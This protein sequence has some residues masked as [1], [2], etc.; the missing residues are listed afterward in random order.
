MIDVKNVL[1]NELSEI[2]DNDV[3]LLLSG[4]VDSCSLLFAL[5]ELNKNVHAYSFTLDDRE[6]SDFKNAKEVCKIFNI[7]FSPIY[8]PTDL[9]ILQKDLLYLI[10]EFN[11]KKKTEIECS[12]AMMYAIKAIKEKTIVAGL[13]ADGHFCISKKGMIHYRHTV[14][15]M[16]EFRNGLFTNPNYSQKQIV[17][18][19]C[20]YHNKTINLPFLS[21]NMVN[22]F[23][24][25]SWEE[26]NKPKQKQPIL[27]AFPESFSKV[28]VRPHTNFQLGDSGIASQFEK[29]LSTDWN[30]H[31]YKS[32]TGIY[33][34][35][36]RGEI[37]DI[38]MDCLY[39][40]R[41]KITSSTKQETCDF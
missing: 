1:L 41:E 12:W 26:I 6:S 15:K 22:L 30:L 20:A 21:A 17:S 8:L 5:L 29:I 34:S 4:G 33:N 31:N 11:L 35:I 38:N 40:V 27:D 25:T 32:V 24:D 28:K 36:A 2:E 18:K 14:E 37:K 7:S 23:K 19:M 3:A 16:N 39:D 10:K 9:G 13:G